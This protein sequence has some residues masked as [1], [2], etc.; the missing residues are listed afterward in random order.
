MFA[1][2]ALTV[3]AAS[4]PTTCVPRA[5]LP[6]E[7]AEA[8]AIAS[9]RAIARLHPLPVTWAVT[10]CRRPGGSRRTVDCDALFDVRGKTD[11]N[12]SKLVIRVRY[13]KGSRRTVASY[14]RD[15]VCLA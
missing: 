11:C 7:R 8:R 9:A 2:V 4:A 13:R 6:I 14:P 3:L 15:P 12:P 1:A 10:N 5:C